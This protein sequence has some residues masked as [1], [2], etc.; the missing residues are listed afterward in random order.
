MIITCPNCQTRYQVADAA[1]GSAGRKV[2]CANCRQAWRARPDPAQARPRPQLVEAPPQVAAPDTDRLFSED[3]E[4]A[5]D[6]KF[7][8]AEDGALKAAPRRA[9]PPEPAMPLR[10]KLGAGLKGIRSRMP[11]RR[12]SIAADRLP[13]GRLLASVRTL[14]VTVLV[15]TV[16]AALYLRTDIVRRVPD[17]AGVYAAIGLPVN[18]VGLEFRNVET[19]RT[20]QN[21]ADVMIISGHIRNITSRQAKVPPIVVSILDGSGTSLYSWSVT[22]AFSLI[23]SGEILDFETQLNA[24]P[25]GAET[26]RL[27]FAEGRAN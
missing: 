7:E 8:E 20:I 25:E 14:G 10:E 16:I 26:V 22:P 6:A 12:Q 2:Q 19:L 27:E 5:L 23:G 4:A 18:V 11:R 13:T 24:S 3:E 15:L 21:G 1:I 9:A 17:L